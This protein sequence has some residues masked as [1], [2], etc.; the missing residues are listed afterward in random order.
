MQENQKSKIKNLYI[1]IYYEILCIPCSRLQMNRVSLLCPPFED[2]RVSFPLLFG[3][4]APKVFLRLGC[5]LQGG[6]RSFSRFDGS[7]C[8]GC[9]RRQSQSTRRQEEENPPQA[10][11]RRNEGREAEQETD[12]CS[13][14]L[15][16]VY[17]DSFCI[18]SA[19]SLCQHQGISAISLAFIVRI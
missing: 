12:K 6:R 13:V 1:R 7:L 4:S 15:L 2:S 10:A 16:R 5:A 8:R 11:A 3:R 18:L 17:F 9:Q 19:S 14:T